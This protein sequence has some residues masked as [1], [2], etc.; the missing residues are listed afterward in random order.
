[1]IFEVPIHSM[2]T[3]WSTGRVVRLLER[4]E[5]QASFHDTAPNP[6]PA[7]EHRGNASKRWQADVH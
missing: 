3:G 6:I 2:K 4:I 7:F 1:M 5:V